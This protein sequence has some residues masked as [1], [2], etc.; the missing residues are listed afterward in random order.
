MSTRYPNSG[1]SRSVDDLFNAF[2]N[3]GASGIKQVVTSIVG[4]QQE[5]NGGLTSLA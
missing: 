1:A 3:D 2:E 4:F 5:I